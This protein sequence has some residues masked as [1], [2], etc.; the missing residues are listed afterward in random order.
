M[1]RN[2]FCGP[3]V[4]NDRV[5]EVQAAACH[6]LGRMGLGIGAMQAILRNGEDSDAGEPSGV[7][8]R[9]RHACAF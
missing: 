6:L 4:P 1:N 9:A 8:E 3:R 5:N 2:R 7:G